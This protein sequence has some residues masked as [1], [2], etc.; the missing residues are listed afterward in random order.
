VTTQAATGAV[1]TFLNTVAGNVAPF[2][3]ED[4]IELLPGRNGFDPDMANAGA[5]MITSTTELGVQ[6][7]MYKFFDINTKKFKYRCDTR[8]GVG[9]VNTEAMGIILFSQS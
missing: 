2:W 9:P 4:S 1:I 6:V 5:Q 8:F 3:R 7:A